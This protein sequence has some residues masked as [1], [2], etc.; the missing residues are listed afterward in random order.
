[1]DAMKPDEN[2]RGTTSTHPIERASD[3]DLAVT[4]R[5]CS[6]ITRFYIHR[7]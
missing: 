1:M 2:Y 4:K 3:F 7:N 6:H 5:I